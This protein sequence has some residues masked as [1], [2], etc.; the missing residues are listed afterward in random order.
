M[1]PPLEPPGQVR[2][3]KTGHR[4]QKGVKRMKKLICLG[5]VLLGS[6]GSVPAQDKE[7]AQLVTVFQIGVADG[8]Y[9]EFA[10]AGNYQAYA[11]TFPHDADFVVGQSDSM[12]DWPWIQPGPSDAWAGSRA[13]TFKIT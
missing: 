6:N 9:R 8:D 4:W 12:K 7:A 11:Q 5:L 10:T 3:A 1:L 2:L 13:H